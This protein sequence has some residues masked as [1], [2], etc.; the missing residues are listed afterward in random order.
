MTGGAGRS[1]GGAGWSTG[2][3]G[4]STGGASFLAFFFPNGSPSLRVLHNASSAPR[5]L[6]LRD[7]QNLLMPELSPLSLAAFARPSSAARSSASTWSSCW[8]I[9]R[10]LKFTIT[11]FK[12]AQP[13][14]A[15]ASPITLFW[16]SRSIWSLGR[17]G[18]VGAIEKFLILL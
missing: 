8:L 2:G 9:V 10:S 6:V 14:A 18:W 4:R 1:T 17:D 5:A 13:N 3:V 15:P 11:H 12:K 16:L 7:C